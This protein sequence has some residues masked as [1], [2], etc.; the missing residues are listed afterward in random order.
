[1]TEP[2]STVR[3]ALARSARHRPDA[4]AVVDGAVRLSYAELWDAALGVA[5]A[6]V[7]AGA[8][9]APVALF[10]GSSW[11]TLAAS[12]G[13]LAIGGCWAPLDA[14][15]PTD[16]LEA[17]MG[18]L[19]PGIVLTSAASERVARHVTPRS[20]PIRVL[21]DVRPSAVPVG[22][23]G[24]GDETSAAYAIATSGST[25]APKVAVHTQ[26]S[27][28]AFCAWAV[29]FLRLGPS[30]RLLALAPPHFDISLLDLWAPIAA[31]AAVVVATKSVLAFP[32][33]LPGVLREHDISVVQSVPS[34]W[35]PSLQAATDQLLPH[36]RQVLLTGE[37]LRRPVAEAIAAR[38]PSATIT[39]VYGMT[40][41]NDCFTHRFDPDEPPV[42]TVPIGQPLPGFDAVVLD[43]EGRPV[44]TGDVGELFVTGP[45]MMERYVGQPDAT[46]AVLVELDQE[47]SGRRWYRTGDLVSV[48]DDGTF[49]WTGRRDRVVKVRGRRCDLDVLDSIVRSQPGVLDAAVLVD[50]DGSGLDLITVLVV[51][52]PGTP[53]DVGVVTRRCRDGAGGG[54]PVK[55]MIV[56][57][58][59]RTERGKLDRRALRTRSTRSLHP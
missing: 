41:M 8:R 55:V 51:A 44:P 34:A 47:P 29:D 53:V 43:D 40:E 7:S 16:Q 30:D 3:S 27:A 13:V 24:E 14:T 11:R 21:D 36:L 17:V 12:H 26:A 25:G 42:G 35:V 19:A 33:G 22:G 38:A 48:A 37:A 56:D 46:R 31:G 58:L 4:V 5:G 28:D 59:P 49:A 10:G 32:V 9:G 50:V 57:A 54:L 20:T 6:V 23:L 1:M 39:N 15:A 2:T 45:T 52:A 18:R